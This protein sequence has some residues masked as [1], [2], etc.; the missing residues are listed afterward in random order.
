MLVRDRQDNTDGGHGHLGRAGRNWIAAGALL[1][2]LAVALG[3][4]GAHALADTLG[5][6]GLERFET[7]AKYQ[8]YHAL[9][10]ILV[11]LL[12]A[13]RPGALLTAAG[14]AF[15]IGILC[16]SGSLYALAL[17][18]TGSFGL[19]APIGGLAFIAG[20]LLAAVAVLRAPRSA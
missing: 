3:A 6:K 7:A 9:G 14:T 8:M 20:W 13:R 17:R 12:W 5:A 15:L 16:F 11:G 4:M 1:A 2:A 10:L 19:I 18:G